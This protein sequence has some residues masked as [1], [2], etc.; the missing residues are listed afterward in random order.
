MTRHLLILA[1]CLAGCSESNPPVSDATVDY[2]EVLDV[3]LDAV[4]D[5][6]ATTDAVSLEDAPMGARTDA[7]MDSRTGA[8]A[9]T[10]ADAQE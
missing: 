5:A 10:R 2:A 7:L 6:N 3:V 9:S 8:D 1:L 4:A